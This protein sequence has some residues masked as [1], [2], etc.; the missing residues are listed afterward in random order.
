MT[1]LIT[2]SK[3]RRGTTYS[4]EFPTLPSLSFLP[5]RVEL[6]QEPYCHDV[7]IMEFGQTSPKWFELVKTGVPIKF[8]WKQ[9]SLSK[10]WVGYVSFI[11]KNVEGSRSQIMEVHCIGSTFS[12]KESATKVF[13]NK[14]IPEIV[15]EIVTDYGFKFVG[16]DNNVK[17]E[18]LA[19]AGHSYWEWIQ[20]HAKS[21][22]YGVLVEN[23]T[24]YFRP[25]DKLIDQ[26]ITNVPVLSMNTKQ[27]GIGNEALDRTLDSFKVINGE[28]VE[29][30]G[31]MR[32][33]KQLGGVDP[34]TNEVIIS[35]SSPDAVGENLRAI[36]NDVL[37]NEV[38]SSKVSNSQETAEVLSEGSAH[39]GR[40][41]M[42]ARVTCQGDPRIRPF[43]PVLI[44]GT[45]N[46]TDGFWIAKEV[47]HMFAM[48]GD[49]Q[50]EMK[51]AIDGIGYDTKFSRKDGIQ[52]PAGVVN[53][54]EAISGNNQISSN[55]KVVLNG[56]KPTMLEANQGYKRTPV[57][58]SN[59]FVGDR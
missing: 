41:N 39:L 14:S 48:I 21:I 10:T 1:E 5:R 3:Y 51:A 36:S 35:I 4:V 20:E 38:D 43:A 13:L 6:I 22:G 8:G 9:G 26:N 46:L 54:T 55:E 53:L 25:L 7:L 17:F 15:K 58:W 19:I 40:F 11:K 59:I 52:S 56:L 47:K 27:W 50:I 23:M 37:F 44:Q 34:L 33:N 12:L 29:T 45:G 57:K 16:E 2:S 49:Y 30:R 24:F 28:H 32:T 31:N 42:P 18:Q